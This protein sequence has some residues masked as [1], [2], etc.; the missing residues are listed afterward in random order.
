[1]SRARCGSR[2]VV[3]DGTQKLYYRTGSS[4]DW[5]LLNDES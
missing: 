5:I 1:M 3:T 2:A 4:S